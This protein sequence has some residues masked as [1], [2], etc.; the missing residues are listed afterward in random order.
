MSPVRT[1]SGLTVTI[2]VLL[3]IMLLGGCE[4]QD[5]GA[6][7]PTGDAPQVENTTLS[8]AVVNVDTI[9]PV[10]GFH[11]IATSVSV[12]ASDPEDNISQ[13]VARVLRLND[14][15]TLAEATLRDDGLSPDSTAGDGVYGGTLEFDIL[16]TE[17]G[18]YRIQFQA[19]DETALASSI[20]ERTLEAQRANSPPTLDAQS[21]IA[22]DTIVRPPT[23]AILVFMSI[24]AA[25][26]DGLADISEVYFR[27]LAASDPTVK[28][29]LLDDGGIIRPNGVTSG[30]L[31]AGDAV[32]SIIIQVP[33]T[34]DAGIYPFA[35]QAQDA[36]A[37]TSATVLHLLTIQ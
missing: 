23:G 30:D 1:V 22:P 28:F 3:G 24:A 2:P 15:A 7:D 26:S 6:I 12:S 5:T 18:L 14:P 16:R 33:S 21:L 35:F 37:D 31:V 20:L 29:I 34:I 10:N 27:N 32:F 11:T 19:T 13:V 4:E 36:F 8:P 25:D 9:T 17:A